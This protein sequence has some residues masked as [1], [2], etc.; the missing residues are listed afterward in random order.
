MNGYSD[1][2]LKHI[3]GGFW[4]TDP[5]RCGAMASLIGI[6]LA[7]MGLY[8]CWRGIIALVEKARKGVVSLPA[9]TAIA[10][11]L[12][13]FAVL[14]STFPGIPAPGS[15]TGAIAFRSVLSGLHTG[16]SV[17]SVYD[18]AEQAFVQEVKHV[19]PPD[20]LII[21]VPDDG[22]AFAFGA[23][24]LRTYYRVTRDY[25]VPEE[26]LSSKII[27]NDLCGIAHNVQVQNA[28]SSIG[29]RYV[30]QLDQGQPVVEGPHLF[31]YGN[32]EKWRGID[33]IRDD[34]PGFTVVL[35]EGHMRLYEIDSY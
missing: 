14:G 2:P 32:G 24:D 10:A 29:A 30:L 8:A 1:G 16:A 4:Y 6:F 26:T 20:A 12:A 18:D 33:D 15:Q 22:S 35:A 21:N 23:D 19:V 34:T 28:V 17:A 11:C 3:F 5:W 31:T 7:A 13:L 25:D 27:R 9:S